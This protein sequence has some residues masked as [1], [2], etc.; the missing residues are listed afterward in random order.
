MRALLTFRSGPPDAVARRAQLASRVVE[1]VVDLDKQL[2]VFKQ[3][4]RAEGG[5]CR[6]PIRSGPTRARISRSSRTARGKGEGKRGDA[7]ADEPLT[8]IV[9]VERDRQPKS[10]WSGPRQLGPGRS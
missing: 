10:R 2:M 4:L 1:Q 5:W 8:Q 3:V 7:P 6:G 9:Q